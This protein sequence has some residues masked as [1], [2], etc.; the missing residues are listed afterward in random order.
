MNLWEQVGNDLDGKAAGDQS[1]NSV[2]ISGDGTIVAVG[3][4]GNDDNGN[5]AQGL[6]R[7]YKYSSE[8]WNQLGYDFQVIRKRMAGRY[9]SL[10]ADGT[11]VAIGGKDAQTVNGIKSGHTRIYQYSSGSWNQN[12]FN[13]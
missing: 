6:T 5:I 11:I 13:H 12:H 4:Y 3:A 1:G 8:S 2:S 7:I 9:I 10:S